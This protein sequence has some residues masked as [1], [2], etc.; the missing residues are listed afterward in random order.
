MILLFN[1][2]DE[3]MEIAHGDRICQAEL[4]EDQ[5]VEIAETTE[6]PVQKTDRVSGFGS[7]G[8]K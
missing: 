2:T 4:F 3:V 7:T 1:T 5:E 8:S 6:R